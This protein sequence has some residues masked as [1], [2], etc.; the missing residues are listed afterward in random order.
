MKNLIFSIVFILLSVNSQAAYLTASQTLYKQNIEAVVP[1]AVIGAAQTFTASW[2]ALGSEIA[3]GG[4][5]SVGLWVDLD[6]NDSVNARVRLIASHTTGGATYLIPIKTVGASS[7]S[8][9]DQYLEFN[10]DEDQKM[11]ISWDL[12]RVIPYLQF[13]VQVGTLN[14]TAAEFDSAHYTLRW[15]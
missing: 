7:V 10:V 12:D 3:S 13:Q 11:F 9:E 15:K 14:T 1:V 4:Y 2:A 8:V 5:S 6:I